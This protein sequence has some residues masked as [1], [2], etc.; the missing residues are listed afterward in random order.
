MTKTN[1]IR[2]MRVKAGFQKVK[3]KCMVRSDIYYS[4]DVSY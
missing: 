1:V 2:T 4:T 3:K